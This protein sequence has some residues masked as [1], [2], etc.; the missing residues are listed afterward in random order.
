MIHRYS[1]TEWISQ[2]EIAASAEGHRFTFSN[3]CFFDILEKA[4][5]HMDQPVGHPNSLGIWL[6]AKEAREFVTVLLSGEGADEVFGGYARFYHASLR[7]KLSPWL[8]LLRTFP[9]IG[10]RLQRQLGGDAIDSFIQATVFLPPSKLAQAR[11]EADLNPAMARRRAIFAEG[12]GDYLSR[13]LKYEMQTYLVDLLVRQDKMTMAHSLEN[14]VPFLDRHLVSFVR[15]LPSTYL[16]S[17]SIALGRSRMRNTKVI[18]KRI[19]RRSF[20]ERFVYRPKAGFALPLNLFFKD[21]RFESLMEDLLLPGMQKRGLVRADTVR[22]WWRGLS[23]L[24]DAMCERVWSAV[25][26]ELWAQQFIAAPSPS[27]Q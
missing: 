5:W 22:R 17:N 11:P 23:H 13:C 1:E 3:H 16:V 12:E 19:A 24:P 21:K 2:A 18:L 6:L 4:T 10:P 27:P 14:R 9:R 8:P 26:L 25:A 20:E 15:T 7:P